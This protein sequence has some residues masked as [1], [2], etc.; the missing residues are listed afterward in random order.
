MHIDHDTSVKQALSPHE[1]MSNSIVRYKNMIIM[2]LS[3]L[4][5]IWPIRGKSRDRFARD[6]D[7]WIVHTVIHSFCG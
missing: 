3:K 1:L 6:H 5:K 2:K 7:R 4:N